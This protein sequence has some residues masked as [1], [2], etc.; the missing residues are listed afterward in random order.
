MTLTPRRGEQ[1]MKWTFAEPRFRGLAECLTPVLL[2]VGREQEESVPPVEWL[3]RSARRRIFRYEPPGADLPACIVKAC[4]I[5][6]F[7]TLRHFRRY[8]RHEYS[9]LQEAVRRGVP[10]PRAYALAEEWRRLLP[11]VCAVVMEDLAPLRPLKALFRDG[12]LGAPDLART[13]ECVAPLFQRV[14]EAGV[15]HID[16][17]AGNVMTDATLAVQPRLLD[18]QYAGFLKEPSPAAL[19]M[20]A[21]R[22]ARSLAEWAPMDAFRGWFQSLAPGTKHGWAN[23]C[24]VYRTP[25]TRRERLRIVWP[26]R[27][28]GA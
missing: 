12:T 26:R 17:A 25:L 5:R 1:T 10:A 15:N 8:G 6:N 14:Y 22:F 19:A 27:G 28:R 2:A 21:A 20:Q 24:L 9:N 23:F 16:L 11:R 13:L 4:P 3:R 7:R 18:F